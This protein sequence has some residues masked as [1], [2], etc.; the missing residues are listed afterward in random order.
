MTT[1]IYENTPLSN[2]ICSMVNKYVD[3]SFKVIH[4]IFNMKINY[5]SNKLK[6]DI[7]LIDIFVMSTM[8]GTNGFWILKKHKNTIN[9]IREM[10]K[11]E[12]LKND[13][14]IKDTDTSLLFYM[15][16][17]IEPSMC[18]PIYKLKCWIYE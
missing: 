11:K 6:D 2:P 5:N 14:V 9:K 16:N 4:S 10:I 15:A 17:S 1:I 7:T 3:N 8:K 18:V 13:I 12:K